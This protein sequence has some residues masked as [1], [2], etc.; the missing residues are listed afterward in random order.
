[1]RN[2]IILFT[3]VMFA[4]FPSVFSQTSGSVSITIS[5]HP[6]QILKINPTQS[7]VLISYENEEDYQQGVVILQENHLTVF[8]TS[9][10]EVSVFSSALPDI[11]TQ[12]QE[13]QLTPIQIGV[14]VPESV[15]G[16]M[17]VANIQLQH[18]KQSII[19]SNRQDFGIS[20]DIEYQGLG[21]NIYLEYQNQS[22][23]MQPSIVSTKVIYSLE[24][25]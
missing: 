18:F 3:F 13:A 17:N 22:K 10:F 23:N 14:L 16:A 24:V 4:V 6:I 25:K 8:S 2:R 19:S 21:E 9:G 5:L 15:S 7:E 1:M 12:G 20:F 11:E